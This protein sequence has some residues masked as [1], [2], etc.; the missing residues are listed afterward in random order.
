MT[1][2]PPSPSF[3]LTEAILFTGESFV[4]G[5]ALLVRDG[6]ILDLVPNGKIPGGFASLPCPEGILAPGFIDCQ[7]NGGGN[8]LFNA[9]PSEETA[10]SIAAAHRKSGTTA[11]LPTV[12]SDAPD[13]L[14]AA[15]RAVRAAR[16]RNAGILG[17][18]IEGPH[19]GPENRGIHAPRH[20][21]P[22]T[23]ADLAL[24][25]PEDGETILV[26]LAPEQAWP[27]AI[28]KLKEQGAIV[29]LGHTAAK[30][31]EIRAALA[32]GA[33]GFT[34]LFNGMGPMNARAPG[35]AGVAL[36]DRESF[37]SLIADGRHVAPE[38]IRLAL[39]AKPEDRLFF[40]SDSMPPAG[41][42]DPA[43][44]A[45]NGETVFPKNGACET[46]QGVLAGAAMPLGEMVSYAIRELKMEPERALRMASA[47]PAAFLGLEKTRGKLLPGY[48]A[49][50]V[51]LDHFFRA[52]EVWT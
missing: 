48:K 10:L 3:A 33:S 46:A 15:L 16:K 9:E 14:K 35:P 18:H 13:V 23:N 52:R 34:H 45:L 50:I 1:A 30:P 27:E 5:H 7:V 40:V 43:P 32:A 12:V 36:D 26:T 39:R 41:A 31:E 37:C 8:L 42:D 28:R 22:L 6:A 19:I 17:I 24:Y 21:R 2:F 44:F 51:A 4:E 25:A 49:D 38:M 29:A 47:V 20:L 11:L